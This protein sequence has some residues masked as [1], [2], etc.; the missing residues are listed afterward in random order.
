MNKFNLLELKDVIELTQHS[1]SNLY[2]MM[3][4]NEFP[5]PIKI[6]ERKARWRKEDIF[7]WLEE[8]GIKIEFHREEY[9]KGYSDAMDYV[10]HVINENEKTIGLNM[11]NFLMKLL[12]E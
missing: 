8:K 3:Q 1:R 4:N 6:G 12:T 5:R 2:L 9:S 7:K 11:S 10:K